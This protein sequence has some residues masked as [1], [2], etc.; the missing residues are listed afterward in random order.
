MQIV[1]AVE[2]LEGRARATIHATLRHLIV[3]E[4]QDINP[5]QDR[6]IALLA[7]PSVEV[8]IVGDDQQA[9]YQW[10]GSDVREH[11]EFA[12]RF[13]P[14]ATFSITVNRRSRPELIEAA[15]DS[16]DRS[17]TGSR[18]RCSRSESTRAGRAGA[19]GWAAEDEQTR[20][21]TSRS[22]SAI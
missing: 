17:R 2:E 22:S 5:A 10:R 19:R 13:A 4:Y 8:C 11:R 9:I 1:K 15:N 14:V 3:D 6:L 20:R 16:R 12:T 7:G 18:R 21:A